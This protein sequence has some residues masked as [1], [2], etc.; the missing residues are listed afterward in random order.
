MI[1]MR[2][3]SIALVA[4]LLPGMAFCQS[5]GFDTL[6]LRCSVGS[7]KV[8]SF[9]DKS[10]CSG[11]ISLSFTGSVLISGL[12]GPA[13]VVTGAVHKEYEDPIHKKQAYFG[14]G[15]IVI[16]G[17]FRNLQWFGR[18]MNGW[19]QGSGIARLYGEY[20]R[21]LNTGFFHYGNQPEQ[22]WLYESGYT[23][24]VPESEHMRPKKAVSRQQ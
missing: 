3:R 20:D 7:F 12:D 17:T 22:S 21:N 8:Q 24:Q 15:K 19:F 10:P 2:I 16:S 6:Y 4:A 18:D 14:T 9:N 1:H 5:N 23:L 13:P 11:K